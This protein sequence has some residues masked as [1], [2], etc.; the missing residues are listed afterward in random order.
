MSTTTRMRRV[1]RL[2]AVTIAGIGAAVLY[3]SVASPQTPAASSRTIAFTEVENKTPCCIVDVAPKSH[4]KREPM[5]SPGDQLVFSQK[6]RDPSGRPIGTLYGDCSAITEAPLTRG[7]FICD[8]VYSFTDGT[9]TATGLGGVGAPTSIGA[10]TG[11][12]GAYANARGT[13]SSKTTRT[14]NDTLV[15]LTG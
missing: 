5:M 7:R 9:M 8:G 2:G 11:G 6:L 14:G 1:S 10:I 3:G 4:G 15:T 12:T 13:F